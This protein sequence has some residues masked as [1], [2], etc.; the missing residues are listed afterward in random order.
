MQRCTT[1]VAGQHMYKRELHDTRTHT[2]S[3][4]WHAST[5]PARRQPATAAACQPPTLP[6][7]THARAASPQRHPMHQVG[8]PS[9]A[10]APAAAAVGATRPGAPA[11]Q[12]T[13]ERPLRSSAG[14]RPAP[15]AARLRTTV[16]PA[17]GRTSGRCGAPPDGGWVGG[18]V[19]V[20]CD[21]ARRPPDE[22]DRERGRS[23]HTQRSSD[24]NY[25]C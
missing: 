11:A 8:A 2:V 12:A 17:G 22:L 16:G 5:A 10:A 13:A 19:V 21:G 23:A 25:V 18:V 7:Q 20:W 4:C 6:G 14:R 15:A 1:T 24:A 3:A 9:Q